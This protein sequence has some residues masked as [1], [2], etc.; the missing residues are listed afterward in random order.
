MKLRADTWFGL[1]FVLMVLLSLLLALEDEGQTILA[2]WL[3]TILLLPPLW[4]AFRSTFLTIRVILIIVFTTQLITVP[5]FFLNRDDFWLGEIKPFD[6]SAPEV[7]IIFLKVT[8]FLTSICIFL[9]TI[10]LYV[11]DINHQLARHSFQAHRSIPTVLKRP[12]NAWMYTLLLLL[13]IATIAPLNIW[14]FRNG[15]SLVGVEPPS[16]PF[17]LSGIL[18]YFTKY[19]VPVALAYLYY[20]SP[21]TLLPALLLL[22]YGLLLGLTSLSRSALVLVV[23]PILGLAWIEKK[24]VVLFAI[25]VGLLISYSLI[26]RARDLV[27]FVADGISG[28]L[29]DSGIL[30]IA[31]S[32]L[33]NLQLNF[34]LLSTAFMAILNRIEGFENLVLSSS[35]DPNAV[36]GGAFG[37]MLRIIWRPFAELDLDQHH[38]QWQGNT[39]PDGYVNGGALLSN[40]IIASNDSPLWILVAAMICAIVLFVLERSVRRI[41]RRYSLPASIEFFVI[42]ILTIFF[43]IEGGGSVTFVLPL[44][45]LIVVA[46]LPR[47]GVHSVSRLSNRSH[48]LPRNRRV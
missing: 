16:L 39:L 8:I 10:S 38:L 17:R 45:L 3:A 19:I 32:L 41:A 44:V 48:T 11:P 34:N 31:I 23:L 36:S 25:G 26:S 33:G 35:Y 7:A 21:R 42:T 15:F 14:M 2:W 13:V 1:G 40:M 47:L 46:W 5:G 4:L 22:A 18:H 27:Y 30:L 28:A 6:Y 29:T 12:K 24:K 43:F 20:K 9:Q 37:F